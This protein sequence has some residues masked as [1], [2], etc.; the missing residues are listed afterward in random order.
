MASRATG[1]SGPSPVAFAVGF[2]AVVA[3]VLLRAGVGVYPGIGVALD[4]ADGC[5]RCPPFP[6]C[7][8]VPARPARPGDGAAARCHH[9]G[10]L[11]ALHVSVLVAGTAALGWVVATRWSPRT[12]LIAATAFAASPAAVVLTAWT[13]SYDVFTFLL[14]SA[15]V[16]ARR[17]LAAAVAGFAASFAAFEQT[18]VSVVL[19]LGVAVVSGDHDRRSAY[20]GGVVGAV[21]GRI[22]LTMWLRAHGITHDRSYWISFFGPSHFLHQFTD[23]LG[24]LLLTA[25]G[26]AVVLVVAA[27]V[28]GVQQ[29]LGRAAWIGALALPLVPVAFTEDQTRVYAM[30]TWPIVFALVLAAAPA[31]TVR[32]VRLLV[33][34]A[35]LLGL[36]LPMF[37]WRGEIHLAEHHLFG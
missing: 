12:A 24:V 1:R 27:L 17:P 9:V 35:L 21:L 32:R 36:A 7:P 2:L 37:V 31:F 15:I 33:P 25:L 19:L 26:G 6:R 3:Y 22:V 14:G 4:I 18:I 13:G 5:R 8:V 11:S 29:R 28:W 23:S 30:I 20:L 34:A 10:P 16:V